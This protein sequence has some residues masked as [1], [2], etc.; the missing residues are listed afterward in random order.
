MIQ[1]T[2]FP[3]NRKAEQKKETNPILIG[4]LVLLGLAVVGLVSFISR[5]VGDNRNSGSVQRQ[6][7]SPTPLQ[8]PKS[9]PETADSEFLASD[10]QKQIFSSF[11]IK[12]VL[13]E[14]LN[15]PDSLQDL[16]VVGS[17]PLKKL[18]G[19][20]KVVVFYRAQN[21]FGA[22]VAQRQTFLVTRG[23]GSGLDAWKVAPI[24]D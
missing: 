10:T 18:P 7:A 24:K 16:R 12:P 23:T 1:K 20:H 2:A 11:F 14:M 8:S 17:S 15:N 6:M 5:N 22:V 19:A 21:A 9:S 13:Q 4:S 3:M